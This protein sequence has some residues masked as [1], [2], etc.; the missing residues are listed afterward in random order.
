MKFKMV[1]IY[2]KIPGKILEECTQGLELNVDG[3]TINVPF[4]QLD[5]IELDAEDIDE[6]SC[7]LV[8]YKGK[9]YELELPEK[10]TFDWDDLLDVV[11][12]M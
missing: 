8:G 6:A 9:R 11:D 10:G 1:D 4:T 12:P 3:E 2:T 7:L 5:R